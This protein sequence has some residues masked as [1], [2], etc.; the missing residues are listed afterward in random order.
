MTPPGPILTCILGSFC[1]WYVVLTSF[2]A[3]SSGFL[4]PSASAFRQSSRLRAPQGLGATQF[5]RAPQ[6]WFISVLLGST[7]FLKFPRRLEAG[8]EKGGRA[9]RGRASSMCV[10]IKSFAE[11]ISSRQIEGDLVTSGLDLGAVGPGKSIACPIMS[12]I[13]CDFKNL[14]TDRSGHLSIS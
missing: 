12:V 10:Y 9:K 1:C 4:G 5:L 2:L 3:Q 6:G 14:R 7:G 11:G 8:G 13:N